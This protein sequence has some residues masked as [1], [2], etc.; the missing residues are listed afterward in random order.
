MDQID[1]YSG[2]VT[3]SGFGHCAFGEFHLC[4]LLSFGT[5]MRPRYRATPEQTTSGNLGKMA[6]QIWWVI[7]T[8]HSGSSLDHSRNT[9]AWLTPQYC[10]LLAVNCI[11]SELNVAPFKY[12]HACCSSVGN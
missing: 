3:V 4:F 9:K 10:R 11:K 6:F 8:R 5:F 2:Q 1:V 12:N 7:L